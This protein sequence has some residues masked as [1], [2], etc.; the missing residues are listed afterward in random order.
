MILL[1]LAIVT[2]AACV[3]ARDLQ[4]PPTPSLTLCLNNPNFEMNLPYALVLSKRMFAGAGVAIEWRISRSCPADGIRVQ[5]RKSSG[6]SDH[7]GALAYARPFIHAADATESHVVI[8]T[9]RIQNTV[10]PSLL[11]FLLSHVLVHEVTHVLQGIE[12]HSEI[13]I[14]KARFETADLAAMRSQSLPF[15]NADLQ[16]IEMGL[17]ARQ[18]QV[19]ID[20][21]Q[22]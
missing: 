19:A 4:I 7:P 21:D 10:I 20:L 5:L 13:G 9:D 12:R 1:T 22:Q 16:L 8:L 11:P 6:R 3:Q 17:R 18:S 14:M 2:A 15:A